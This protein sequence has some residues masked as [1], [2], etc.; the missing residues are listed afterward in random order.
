MLILVVCLL[1]A[2][3]VPALAQV[4]AHYDLSWHV[5]GGGGGEAVGAGHTLRGT[6]GQPLTGGMV[7]SGYTLCSGFWC[8]TV[9]RYRV[10]LPLVVRSAP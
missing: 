10:F 4:S 3:A 6:V 2:V 9:V 1:L 5:I 7:S 8:G